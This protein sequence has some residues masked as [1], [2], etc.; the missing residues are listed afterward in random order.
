MD[1]ETV[2]KHNALVFHLDT[3]E[4]VLESIWREELVFLDSSSIIRERNVFKNT[5]TPK[6][7][8]IKLEFLQDSQ[9]DPTDEINYIC[10]KYVDYLDCIHIK[11]TNEKTGFLF[12]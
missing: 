7:M 9:H 5:P 8:I 10:K 2:A 6:R 1:P 4:A 3:L 12:Q 11:I